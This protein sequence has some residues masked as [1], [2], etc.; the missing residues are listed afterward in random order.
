MPHSDECIKEEQ[1]DQSSMRSRD[2]ITGEVT[3]GGPGEGL[4]R[5]D[6]AVDEDRDVL[7]TG[8]CGDRRRTCGGHA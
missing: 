7:V 5:A 1:D 4:E 6:I 8:L 2:L 3:T